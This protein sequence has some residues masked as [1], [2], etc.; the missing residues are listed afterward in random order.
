MKKEK[1]SKQREQHMQRPGGWLGGKLQSIQE[2]EEARA[3]IE[4]EVGW[5]LNARLRRGHRKKWPKAKEARTMGEPRAHR[6]SHP[7]VWAWNLEQVASP[8]RAWVFTPNERGITIPILPRFLQIRENLSTACKRPVPVQKTS[9]QMM[10][11]VLLSTAMEFLGFPI[12]SCFW[13]IC[14]CWNL[15]AD[16][17]EWTPK[18]LGKIYLREANPCVCSFPIIWERTPGFHRNLVWE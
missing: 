11:T 10:T 4:A 14:H 7:P 3:L 12:I 8:L 2:G 17:L 9:P 5:A 16:K 6:L 15:V 1:G 18:V 13:N